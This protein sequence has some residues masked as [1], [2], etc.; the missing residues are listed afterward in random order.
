M[1]SF[2]RRSKKES[3]RKYK[4]ADASPTLD[5]CKNNK[6][7]DIVVPTTSEIGLREIPTN[8]VISDEK[9]DSNETMCENTAPISY[10]HVVKKPEREWRGVC[11]KPCGHG[12]TA[13]SPSVPIL[14]GK[15]DTN[16]PPSSPKL[17]LKKT[18]KVEQQNSSDKSPTESSA[19]SP[20]VNGNDSEK[21]NLINQ[22]AKFQSQL[23]DLSKQLSIRDA[24]ATKLRFQME[25]LQRDVFAKSAGMDRLETELQA[26]HKE[27]ELLRQRIRY[28][29]TDLDSY[30]KRNNELVTELTEKSEHITKYENETKAKIEELEVTIK[31]LEVKI[32]TLE[33]ELETLKKEKQQLEEQ[34]TVILAERD[35][36]KQKVEDILE[37]ATVQKQ[38]I[39]KK[40]KQDFEKLRTINIMKEQ[41]LLDDFEW[42]LREVQQTCKKRLDD[43]DKSIEERV[44][45]AYKEAERKMQEAEKMMQQVE[46]MK[47]YEIEIEKL[48]G[49]TE[50]QEN[51]IKEMMEQQEQMKQAENNLKNETKRLRNLIELEKENI[52]HI[53]L[54]HHQEILDKERV[55]QQTLHQKRTEIAMY[56][57]E[58][59]LRECGRLKSELEQIHNEEKH[60]AMETI[61][62][63]KD[64]EFQKAQAEWDKKLK[65]C[66]KEI[67]N[68]KRALVQKDEFYRQEMIRTQTNTDRDIMELRRLMDKIDMSHHDRFEKLVQEHEVELERV[69]EETEQKIKEIED[70]WQNKVTALSNTLELVK[71]QME[72]ESQ[73]KIESLIEQHRSELDSQW[74]NLISQKSEA[75]KLVEDEYVMKYKTLEEQF[76]TQQKS[77]EAR[78]VELLKAIDSL[79]NELGS[80]ESALDD[81]QSN[82]DTLEGGIQVLN[83]EIAQQNDQIIKT[84]KESDQKIRGLQETISK[85]HEQQ[86]KEREAY[87]LKF[88]AN[89]KQAQETIDH[90]QRKCQCLTKLFE[91]VRLRYE[92]RESRQEDLN[93]ISDLRQV[94]AEQEK[95]LACLN[96]E[97]RYFQ[98]RLISLEKQLE[99]NGSGDEDAF[100]DAEQSKNEP[101]SYPPPA[102]P[103]FPPPPPFSIPPTIPECDE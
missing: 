81:L 15:R 14:V 10:A 62:K 93:I 85:L 75:V 41:Q 3:D 45:Q 19:N 59:L 53:Q 57:E 51:A 77:H 64:E 76:T 38:E 44:Q 16:T 74:E 36:E 92:R 60:Y 79:K 68:L 5:M 99:E 66:L 39:E 88:M 17:D 42:K 7:E 67:S 56:W 83:N 43:K 12:T 100:Q 34:R 25:E 18:T 65:E 49:L 13:I 58:R 27:C 69:S 94:I 20:L 29:E 98:M 61:R 1:F 101:P 82:V 87:R 37:Q 40:W 63:D 32:T 24:E 89:Q 9:N 84:K 8:A 70:C 30:K 80:K 54:K 2:F 103:S 73:Q 72:K 86:E 4:D 71:E 6:V 22:E 102:Y 47:S 26:A 46:A 33:N 96:E 90:L 78:E 97:K 31:E 95:D 52:Q 11:V 35:A 48:R 21:K 50:D 91:E 23:N 28:L 55:L